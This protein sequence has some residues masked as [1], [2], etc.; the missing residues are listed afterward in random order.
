MAA[1]AFGAGPLFPLG[2]RWQNNPEMGYFIREPYDGVL[3]QVHVDLGG[4]QT[5]GLV[6]GFPTPKATAYFFL[7]MNLG[8]D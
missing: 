7:M 4:N 5:Y 2:G 3:W 8:P 6:A 1:L